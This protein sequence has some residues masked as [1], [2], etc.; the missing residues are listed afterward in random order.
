MGSTTVQGRGPSRGAAMPT[1]VGTEKLVKVC[2]RT[3]VEHEVLVPASAW[4]RMDGAE[5]STE[6]AVDDYLS[7]LETGEYDTG[8]IE[9]EVTLVEHGYES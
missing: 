4:E 9:R 1:R 3:V 8:V 7:D 2:W 5:G 6:G